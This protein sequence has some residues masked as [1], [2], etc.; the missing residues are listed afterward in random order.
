MRHLMFSG[1]GVD[2][3]TTKALYSPWHS[4]PDWWRDRIQ[5]YPDQQGVQWRW[6]Q[7]CWSR[8]GSPWLQPQWPEVSTWSPP[9]QWNHLG[10][11]LERSTHSKRFK[12]VLH[13][14]HTFLKCYTFGMENVPWITNRWT[15]INLNEEVATASAKICWGIG[16]DNIPGIIFLHWRFGRVWWTIHQAK[17]CRPTVETLAT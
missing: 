10:L 11:W 3:C 13:F 16:H 15:A 2:V 8:W 14:A 12:N 9:L 4:R 1:L 5:R 7:S 6:L 17:L